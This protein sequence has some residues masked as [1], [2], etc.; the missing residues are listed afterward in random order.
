[1]TLAAAGQDAPLLWVVPLILAAGAL[2]G[3]VNGAGRRLL[4]RA[5]DHHDA[6]RQRHPAGRHP[7]LHRR[8][9]DRRPR[10]RPDP[11][12]GGRADRP[13][14]PSSR[15]SGSCSRSSPRC[16]C[17]RP[18]SAASSMR[19]A[20]ARRWPSSRAC[21]PSARR[22]SPT[23]CPAS[24]RRSP[25]CSSPAIPAR[26]ISAWATPTSSPRSRPWRSAARRSSAAAATISAPS[27]ARF[28]L[29]ILTG[30]L[31]A[32][33]LSN[34]A[35]LIVYGVVILITVSL[36][37]DARL[38]A[39]RLPRA[40]ACRR[41][42]RAMVEIDCVVDAK[43]AARRRHATGTP[44]TRCCGGSTSGTNA[45]HRYDPASGKDET[46]DAPEYLG[47]LGLREKGGLVLSM[48]SGFLLLRSRR[49]ASFEPIVD[50]EARHRRRRASTT[51]RPTARA[52]SGRAPCSRS[53][54]QPSELIGALYRL[55]PDLSVHQMIE[56]VGCSNG[57]AWSPDSR[58]MYF[59][60]SHSGPASGPM[61]SIRR[62][63]RSRTAA[64]SST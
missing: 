30:L 13:A 40:H 58:T 41:G 23:P 44:R 9:A 17:R 46:F 21:R 14:S 15:S 4:R 52:A 2:V 59:T 29:T 18:R 28:V 50:P 60:D 3:A 47:C 57:L 32:L 24:R 49:R 38:P 26:P 10:R 36:G 54:G 34:G 48:A 12:P 31:P 37:S 43:A 25:A 64:S 55:D 5:A 35:L 27:P 62:P 19:S 42:S 7:R 11:V 56:G 61:I 8:L 6:G 53:P 33:N 63:A 20:P 1:M 39:S 22:C 51:A 16:C 45:I